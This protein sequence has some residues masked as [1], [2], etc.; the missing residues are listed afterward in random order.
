MCA[1][2][3]RSARGCGRRRQSPPR[4]RLNIAGTGATGHRMDGC[5]DFVIQRI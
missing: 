2:L 1:D 3:D 4:E 5:G